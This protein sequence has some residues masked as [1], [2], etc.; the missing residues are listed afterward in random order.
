MADDQLIKMTYRGLD[1]QQRRYRELVHIVQNP[2]PS[3]VVRAVAEVWRVN[4]DSEGSMVGGW[5]P[6]AEMTREVRKQRG[7]NPDY[8]ILKQ[9]GVLRRVA[10][11]SL[12]NAKGRSGS[13]LG[14]GAVM[15]W[16]GD[17]DRITLRISGKKVSNQFRM[18]SRKRGS[19]NYSSPPRRFWFTSPQVV[20]AAQTALIKSIRDEFR[21]T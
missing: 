16:Q 6:L 2:E 10:I 7:F 1:R 15:S 18:Q 17:G 5:R 19:A 8:P 3:P 20:R 14:K 13:A 4:F 21:R 11:E 9:Y 12:V